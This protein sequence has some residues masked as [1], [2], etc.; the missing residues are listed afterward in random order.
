MSKKIDITSTALEKGFDLAKEFL[1]KLIFPAVEETGLLIKDQITLWKFKNQVSILI[2]A[3]EYCDK[4]GITPKTISLKILCP[5]LDNAALEEDKILQDK[6]AILLSNLVDSEQNIQ[7]HVFPYI[8][9]Q[10]STDEFLFLE[11]VLSDKKKRMS[12][13]TT[14]LEIFIKDR[15]K[16]E[17]E[18]KKELK[19]VEANIE[20]EIEKGK[21]TYSTE[22]R[23]LHKLKQDKEWELRFLKYREPSIL[24][25]INAPQIIPENELREF[26]LSNLIRLGLVKSTQ[27]TFANSQTL[28][29]PNDL[30]REHEHDNYYNID[31]EIEIESN[32][33]HVLTELGELFLNACTEKN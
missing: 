26:E 10:I 17:S 19:S 21:Q 32:I 28:E 12:E 18:I 7:N 1:D 5:L 33:E 31:L 22:I 9:G 2:K 14:E 29:I 13:L 20:R 15:P 24:R 4:N 23:D 16:I 11:K 30:E 8:L 27:E 25:K 3:K 6:W